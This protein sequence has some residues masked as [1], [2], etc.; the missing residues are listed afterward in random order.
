[1]GSL[2]HDAFGELRIIS[3]V[4]DSGRSRVVEVTVE[5]TQL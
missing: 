5:Q 4:S 3:A 1:M 2:V